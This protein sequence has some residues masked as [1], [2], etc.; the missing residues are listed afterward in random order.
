M[1]SKILHKFSGDFRLHD[2]PSHANYN[3][4][5]KVV[6][7]RHEDGD[8]IFLSNCDPSLPT[9]D[10]SSEISVREQNQTQTDFS[11]N[12][13]LHA[14]VS[15]QY[16][17]DL[18]NSVNDKIHSK[19]WYSSVF[20]DGAFHYPSK[21]STSSNSYELLEDNSRRMIKLRILAI[22]CLIESPSNH[23]QLIFLISQLAE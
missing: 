20:Y 7:N 3:Q 14:S 10:K 8:N 1:Y 15:F 5:L 4:G 22:S 19:E 9:L 6:P 16:L 21:R 18:P 2:R 11:I 23:N 17:E 13:V 12:W